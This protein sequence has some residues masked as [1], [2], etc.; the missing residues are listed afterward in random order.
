MLHLTYMMH[1]C[2][3][4]AY[5]CTLHVYIQHNMRHLHYNMPVSQSARGA[6]K[7]CIQIITVY[8]Y[9]VTLPVGYIYMYL[10]MYI[11][12]LNPALLDRCSRS[13]HVLYIN[14]CM[15]TPTH[16]EYSVILCSA[17]LCSAPDSTVHNCQLYVLY[18]TFPG[19]FEH[20]II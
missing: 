1:A 18:S 20:P 15:I 4:Q 19:W 13:I 11:T 2:M 7:Q 9:V 14:R 10:R 5:I 6:R 3:P 8:I 12:P 16:V 17:L